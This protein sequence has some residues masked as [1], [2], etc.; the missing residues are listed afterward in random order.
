VIRCGL[1]GLEAVADGVTQVA[2]PVVPEL[3]GTIAF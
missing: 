1:A 3:L 2:S